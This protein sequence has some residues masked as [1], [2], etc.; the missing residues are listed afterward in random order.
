MWFYVQMALPLLTV[1]LAAAICFTVTSFIMGHAQPH[2]VSLWRADGS[3]TQVNFFK[4]QVLTQK[5]LL[6]DVVTKVVYFSLVA[7]AFVFVAMLLMAG[8]HS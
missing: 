3:Q 2:P 4:E 7:T 8:I 1:G 6:S 5:Y